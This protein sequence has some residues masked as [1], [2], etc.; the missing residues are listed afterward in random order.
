MATIKTQLVDGQRRII[1][2]VVNGQRRVS[3]SCCE[4]PECC[5]YPASQ[6]G[7]GY[8]A[9]DLPDTLEITNGGT[10]VTATKSG[11]SYPFT[12]GI[13]SLSLQV[14][15]GSWAFDPAPDEWSNW[16]NPCLITDDVGINV[17]DTF[18]DT[19]TINF[20]FEGEDE[21]IQETVIVTRESLCV[22]SGANSC[23]DPVELRYF[24]QGGT[25]CF[26]WSVYF[27]TTELRQAGPCTGG[28]GFAAVKN[29]TLNTPSGDYGDGE[30]ASVGITV[31]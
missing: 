8:T 17:K 7:V 16:V 27:T 1:T 9:S 31:S 25:S 10:T 23:G 3:C 20:D 18:E 29:G 4:E 14:I 15:G 19:Y 28:Q 2:K 22:W 26:M 30:G 11:S 5:M 6:L 24:C 12:F 13:N 21:T